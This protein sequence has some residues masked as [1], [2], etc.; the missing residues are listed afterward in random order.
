MT[1]KNKG[2]VHKR[3]PVEVTIIHCRIWTTQT[4]AQGST[5][6]KSSNTEQKLKNTIYFCRQRCGILGSRS[7][8]GGL[9]RRP[10]VKTKCGWIV[11]EQFK[12]QELERSVRNFKSKGIGGT[13]ES[14]NC[15]YKR[16]E[17]VG[18]IWR[19]NQKWRKVCCTELTCKLV[20]EFCISCVVYLSQWSG[21]RW[22]VMWWNVEG[23]VTARAA[24][25]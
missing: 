19:A 12:E 24:W 15:R 8:Q 6:S 4:A 13:L 14:D 7:Q 2:C 23:F 5:L 16:V 17:Q 18:C 9:W 21:L 20:K 3:V 10:W 11:E 1:T 25:S 22:G